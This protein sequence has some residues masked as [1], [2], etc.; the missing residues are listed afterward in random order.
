MRTAIRAWLSVTSRINYLPQRIAQ[1]IAM[2][3]TYA[4]IRYASRR[5]SRA[6]L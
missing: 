1:D 5:V 6:G 4:R 2:V 3:V